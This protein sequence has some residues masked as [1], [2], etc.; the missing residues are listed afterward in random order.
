MATYVLVH[1]AWSASFGYRQIAANLRAAGHSVY[2]PT[3]TGLGERAHLASPSITLS[4]HITD[5]TSLIDYERL[6]DIILVGHSYGGMVIT[7]TASE[8]ADKIR[9]LVYLDAFLPE[10]RQALWDLVAD[11]GRKGFIDRQRATPG[12]IAP[13]GGPRPNNPANN[14]PILTVL[15]PVKVSEAAKSIRNRTYIYA[16][17][18]APTSFTKFH[19]RLRDDPAWRVHEIATS[20]FVM[21]DDPDGLTALLLA[22]AER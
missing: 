9:T 15:E 12:L 8:R 22:E 21:Q 11:E 1:G 4:T 20:H 13:P 3:M 6:E 16:T 10:D 7:G 17:A 18:N 5:I 19:A 14:Q 2:A